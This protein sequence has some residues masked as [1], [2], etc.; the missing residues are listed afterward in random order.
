MLLE[1][2]KIWHISISSIGCLANLLLTYVALK[3]TPNATKS[4][5]TLII[6]FA[7][8][9][10]AECFLD[11]FLLVRFIITPMQTT[12]VYVFHGMCQYTGALSCKIGLS[13]LLHCY[14]H[15][16]WSLLLSFSYR[17]YILNRPALTRKILVLLIL[18]AYMP[19]LFQALTYWTVIVDREQILPL[20]DEFFPQYNLSEE[21]GII[22]GVTTINTFPGIF[23]L[24]HLC[25]PIFPIYVAIIVLRAKIVKSLMKKAEMMSKDLRANHK[26]ILKCLTI[27]AMI[28]SIFMIAILAYFVAQFG[29]WTHP[30]LEH[31]IF[32]SVLP[33]PTLSP[34]TYLVY[35]RPY[36]MFCLRMLPIKR[37]AVS[38]GKSG[39]FYSTNNV[40]S[41]GIPAK[42]AF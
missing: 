40:S 26:Q 1:I 15:S 14:P 32:A 11:L 16:A 42:Y 13:F 10:F 18:L 37:T 4:Y 22:E 39:Q 29:I 25:L 24:I 12:L 21:P 19:S 17:Y 20:I 34:F 6:N 35:I 36:R 28:P 38:S 41:S 5:A 23:F 9:D 2:S 3:K 33:M 27:Q 30:I 31:L 8:T 7:I